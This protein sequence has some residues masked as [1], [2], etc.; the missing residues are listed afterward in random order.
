[1]ADWSILAG[2]PVA[3]DV[4]TYY[5]RMI[6]SFGVFATVE[7]LYPRFFPLHNLIPEDCQR[8]PDGRMQM[9]PQLRLSYQRME[10][11]GAYLVGA[12]PTHERLELNRGQRT[13]RRQYSGS[14]AV[15]HPR[16]YRICTA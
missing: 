16:Y 13:A 4:R 15:C 5:M 11:H 9:P 14:A 3:S 6:K 10:A 12:W 7:L 2:G 8:L 1:M